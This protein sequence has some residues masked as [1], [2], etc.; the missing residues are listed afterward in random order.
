MITIWKK[1]SAKELEKLRGERAIT[2]FYGIND[3]SN[4]NSE[5]QP[6]REFASNAPNQ[7]DRRR[8]KYLSDKEFQTRKPKE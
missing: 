5:Q 6:E 2:G 1:K 3:N 7:F 4:N 8:F